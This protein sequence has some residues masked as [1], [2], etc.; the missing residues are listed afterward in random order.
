MVDESIGRLMYYNHKRFHS[1]TDYISPMLF[2][3]N[4][5]AAQLKVDAQ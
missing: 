5:W 4:R 2:E 1:T 3:K